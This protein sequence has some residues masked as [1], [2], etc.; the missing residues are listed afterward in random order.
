MRSDPSSWWCLQRSIVA[1][2]VPSSCGYWPQIQKA[3]WLCK[4]LEVHHPT[5][6]TRQ[7][8]HNRRYLA[9]FNWSWWCRQQ[10]IRVK[11]SFAGRAHSTG[12]SYQSQMVQ[13]WQP[14]RPAWHNLVI[15]TR[16]DDRIC[17]HFVT[18]T[19][20]LVDPSLYCQIAACRSKMFARPPALTSQLTTS[21]VSKE[22]SSSSRTIQSELSLS[23]G[24]E[25]P[26]Q[27]TVYLSWAS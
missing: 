24:W 21:E 5:K 25:A 10:W 27:T 17:Y 3:L 13:W 18:H 16:S 22:R 20:L 19:W 9:F 11:A 8:Y 12:L 6:Q 23:Q 2:L 26:L 4:W 1:P 7:L 15:W 14:F